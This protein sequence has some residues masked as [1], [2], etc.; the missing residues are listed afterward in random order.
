MATLQGKFLKYTLL[1][2]II[3]RLRD[4]FASGFFHSAF[5]IAVI[6]QSVRLLPSG[7]PYTDPRNFGRFGIRHVMAQ[8]ANNLVFSRKN[9]DQVLIYFTVLTGLVLLLTQ[10]IL[11]GIA[12]VAQQPAL[13]APANPYSVTEILKVASSLNPSPDQDI[14]LM[15]MDRVFGIQNIFKSCVS[16]AAIACTDLDGNPTSDPGGAYPFPFHLALHT[17]LRFYSLGIFFVSVIIITYYVIT[18]TAETAASGTPFGQRFNKT[19]VPVRMIVFFA[20]LVPLNVSATAS[21]NAG[22]NAA[23]IITFWVAKTGSNFATNGWIK[24]NNTITGTYLGAPD[25]L[26]ATPAAPDMGALVRFMFVARACKFAEEYS[27]DHGE[28]GVMPYIVREKQSNPLVGGADARDFLTMNFDEALRF[29]NYGDIEV[30]FGELSEKE[31]PGEKGFVKTFC[32]VLKIPVTSLDKPG[33]KSGANAVQQFYFDLIKR[34]WKDA[35][36]IE[37]AR[38]IRDRIMQVDHNPNC[39]PWRDLGF[40]QNAIVFWQNDVKSK[41]PAFVQQQAASS[42]WAVTPRIKQAGWAGAGIWYNRIAQVNGDI[43]SAVRGIPNAVHYPMVMEYVAEQ[44]RKTNENVSPKFIYDP[45]LTDGKE[46]DYPRYKDRTIAAILYNA[47]HFWDT[48][49]AGSTS[50][51]A[52]SSN[53]VL[54]AINFVFGSDGV[55]EMRRNPDIHPLAQLSSLGS[56]IMMASIRNLGLSYI[57]NP[58]IAKILPEPFRTLGT[59]A[60]DFLGKVG[61]TTIAMGFVLYYVLPF[62]PFVYMMFAVGGW[63]KSIFEAI[64]AMPLWALAHL[65]IDAEGLPGTAAATG[66]FLLMEI[67]LRPILIVFGILISVTLFAACVKA[68]NDIFNI[69]VANVTGFDMEA[70]LTGIGPTQIEYYRWALDQ[71]FFSAIYVILCYMMGIGMFKLIDQIPAQILRWMGV[72]TK[73]FTEIAGDPAQELTGKA[74]K[75]VSLAAQKSMS[76]GQLAT[77]LG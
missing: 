15:M 16:Q 41:I 25:N 22:L 65:R 69:L 13:A 54:K 76:G 30:R 71:F 20:L 68:L 35:T 4:I 14:A 64:I 48:T 62:L 44:N 37:N 34:I 1:P 23:Q 50:T 74:Y 52:E 57:G 32:G 3:P 2:G 77:L 61:A 47:Y 17:M 45:A 29:S 33:L 46:S 55:F 18:V 8:A 24:F 56:G 28:D 72:S 31:Y 53:T 19:W 51:N 43:T 40:A 9:T 66:Y 26:V 27:Y 60:A 49:G 6:F 39:A 10:F 75:G 38:C 36:M 7:H 67:F 58:E 11:L 73:T 21:A 63:V 59:A 70:E 12:L 5:L 42:D